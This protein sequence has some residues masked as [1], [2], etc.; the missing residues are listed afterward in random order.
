MLD[1]APFDYDY[2]DDDEDDAL[3]LDPW[4][5]VGA[6]TGSQP[7]SAVLPMPLAGG[8]GGRSRL[9]LVKNAKIIRTIEPSERY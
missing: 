7:V 5:A 8:F 4:M 2:E 1:W 3:E 9:P 6:A